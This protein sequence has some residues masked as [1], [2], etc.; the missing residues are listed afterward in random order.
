MMIPSV[1][2]LSLGL[3]ATMEKIPSIPSNR[4]HLVLIQQ[5][6]LNA[7]SNARAATTK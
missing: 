1:Q 7:M 6:S 4:Y 3:R 5:F 2:T